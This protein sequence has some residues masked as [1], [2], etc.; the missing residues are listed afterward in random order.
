MNCR[1]LDIGRQTASVILTVL[2]SVVF[3]QV[4]NVCILHAEQVIDLDR[5]DDVRNAGF[6]A[7]EPL[8]VA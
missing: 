6:G 8:T 4:E 1:L 3:W 5:E 2:E 7:M